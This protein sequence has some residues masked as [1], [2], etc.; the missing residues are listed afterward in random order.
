MA[1]SP[2]SVT[3][4]VDN[5]PQVKQLLV[6]AEVK[7]SGD[8]SGT[9]EGYANVKNVIDAYGDK[10]IDGAYVGLDKLVR[11]GWL[12]LSHEWDE[13]QIG[14][15]VESREDARGLYF[16]AQFHSTAEAQAVRTTILERMEAG[17]SVAFSIGYFAREWEYST[18]EGTQDTIRLLKKIEVFEISIVTMPANADSLATSA[19]SVP[20]RRLEDQLTEAV[21]LVTDLNERCEW[22]AKN[23]EGGLSAARSETL[24]SLAAGMKAVAGALEG[25][26]QPAPEPEKEPEVDEADLVALMEATEKIR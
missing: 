21:A 13:L 26:A 18:P 15:I 14:M 17:K 1:L 3:L 7:V 5:K 25:V 12:A 9:I 4:G 2:L 11:D 6:D 19:K 24:L 10:V 22:I 8:G 20:G 16:K 23:R